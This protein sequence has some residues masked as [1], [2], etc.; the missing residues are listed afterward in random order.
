VSFGRRKFMVSPGALE[1]TRARRLALVWLAR[2]EKVP[3]FPLFTRALRQRSGDL[4]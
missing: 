2:A 3:I 1:R 4:G